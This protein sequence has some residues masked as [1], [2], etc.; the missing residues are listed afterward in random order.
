MS[1]KRRHKPLLPRGVD[2]APKGEECATGRLTRL[3]RD[4]AGVAARQGTRYFPRG[5]GLHAPTRRG[6]G[7][8]SIH[9]CGVWPQG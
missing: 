1:Q 9:K 2:H 5:D 3:A 4:S 8:N 6:P 7:K